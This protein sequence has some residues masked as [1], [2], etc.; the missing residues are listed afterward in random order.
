MEYAALHGMFWAKG[1]FWVT[2][3]V[4]LFVILYGRKILAFVVKMLDD[5][6]DEIG[7][8]LDEAVRLRAEAEAMRK[9]AEVRKNEAMIRARTMLDDAS[10]EA[11]RL[12]ADLIAEAQATAK[13]RE[14]MIE[15]QIV[16]MRNAVTAEIQQQA[17]ALACRA[18]E[19]ILRQSI[20]TE[21]GTRLI[22]SSIANIS[23]ALRPRAA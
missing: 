4:L 6:S 8:Q 1:T 21:Q 22:D 5:R 9:D 19:I 13:R 7:R 14:Q 2:A 20:D 17:V 10:R 16:A 23:E 15:E 11:E 3:A 18:T 12:A